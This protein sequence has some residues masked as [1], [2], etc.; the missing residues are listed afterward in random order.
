M[1]LIK[2]LGVIMV[3]G[4]RVAMIAFGFKLMFTEPAFGKLFIAMLTFGLVEY[5]NVE[6]KKLK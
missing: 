5:L 4:V 6:L 3:W 1:K 2:K